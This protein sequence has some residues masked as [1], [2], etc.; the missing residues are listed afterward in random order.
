V[1]EVRYVWK[2]ERVFVKTVELSLAINVV[3]A[4]ITA[5]TTSYLTPWMTWKLD[6]N[7]ELRSHRRVLVERWRTEL[8]DIRQMLPLTSVMSGNRP[9][10]QSAASYLVNHKEFSSLEGHLSEE[11]KS[12]L[13]RL[14]N[15]DALI[16]DAGGIANP[17]PYIVRLLAD[18]IF[19]IEKNWELV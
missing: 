13:Y 3:V 11:F 19:R 12:Q 7:K 8:L 5:A 16:I 2:H 1:H 6:K 14:V 9:S 10:A 18:E 4:A 17:R 15:A